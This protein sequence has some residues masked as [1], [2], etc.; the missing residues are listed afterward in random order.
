MTFVEVVDSLKGRHP[1]VTDFATRSAPNSAGFRVPGPVRHTC[2]WALIPSA[3]VME[4]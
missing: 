1:A 2:D 4:R 3:T